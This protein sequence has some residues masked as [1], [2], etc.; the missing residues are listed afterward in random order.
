MLFADISL[1]RS[2]V[3]IVSGVMSPP[4][5]VMTNAPSIVGG[6]FA[7]LLAYANLPRKYSALMKLKTSPSGA[8]APRN[9]ELN[10]DSAESHMSRPPRIP[11]IF[12]GESRKIRREA[13][14]D[15]TSR[16]LMDSVADWFEESRTIVVSLYYSNFRRFRWPLAL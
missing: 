10:S 2:R 14:S 9:R 4:Q 16:S 11:A 6:A 15:G 13:D 1:K 12:A 7:N 3:T 5:A 8:P